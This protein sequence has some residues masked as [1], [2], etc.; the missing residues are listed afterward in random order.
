MRLKYRDESRNKL[1]EE[2]NQN[3]LMS[4]KQKMVC[5]TLCRKLFP[6]LESPTIFVEVFK[7]TSVPFFI[8][9]SN[10]LSSELDNYLFKVSYWVIL[11]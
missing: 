3:E 10:F 2:I 5:T 1:L 11:Y 8:P 4:R 7:A 6:L 9:D